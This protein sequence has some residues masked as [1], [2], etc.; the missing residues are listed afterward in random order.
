MGP[1]LGEPVL[2]GDGLQSLRADGQLHDDVRLVRADVV[3][4]QGVQGLVSAPV[5]FG[6]PRR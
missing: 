6:E 1:V 2:L 5:A 4:P 3:A